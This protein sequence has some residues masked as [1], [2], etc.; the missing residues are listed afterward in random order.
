MTGFGEARRQAEGLAVAVETRT[1][2]NRFFKLSLKCSEGY[3]ALESDIETVARQVVKRGTLN[4]T[5]RLERGSRADDYELDEALLDRYRRQVEAYEPRV[6]RDVPLAAFLP[7]PGV[8]RESSAVGREVAADW[9]LIRSVLEEALS[10][11]ADMRQQEGARLADDLRVNLAAIAA[12]LEQVATRAPLVTDA[13]R[14]R[15]QDRLAAILA[16]SGVDVGPADVLKEAGIFAER[17]DISEEVVRLR[18]HLEQFATILE[19]ADSVGR[20]LDFLTQEMFREANT[21]GS[22]A[23]DLAI[24]RHVIDVKT[25]IERIREMVQN[26]E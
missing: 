26:V 22:K 5:I 14:A 24:A 8:I 23:N 12:E 4:V 25:A 17:S 3:N 10:N 7:L 11:L 13:Y 19:D 2:N 9:P 20:K 18:S 16:S 1:V 15:L 21:I 6:G